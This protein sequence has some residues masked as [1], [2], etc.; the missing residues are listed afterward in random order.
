MAVLATM[1]VAPMAGAA[2][3]SW[4]TWGNGASPAFDKLTATYNQV[5][6]ALKGSNVAQIQTLFR[7]YSSE[8][9]TFAS[10]A[11]SPNK[12][13]N[14]D[15]LVVAQTSNTWAWVG[16]IDV[17][18]ANPNL[19]SWTLINHQNVAALAKLTHDLKALGE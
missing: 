6:K 7:T 19:N 10:Y 16:Y 5:Q 4:K 8:S 17:G 9:V 18:E 14:A 3:N 1:F 13:V 15:V 12:T 11:D 2:G